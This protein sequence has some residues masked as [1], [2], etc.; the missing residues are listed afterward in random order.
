MPI[1][2]FEIVRKNVEDHSKKMVLHAENVPIPYKFSASNS[3]VEA[4]GNSKN[5]V[6]KDNR[7]SNMKKK[8]Y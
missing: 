8:N 4:V 6:Y 2:Y 7:N 3:V 1:S 5:R